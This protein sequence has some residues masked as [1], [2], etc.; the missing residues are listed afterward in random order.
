M[1]IVVAARRSTGNRAGAAG[2]RW[3]SI[4]IHMHMPAVPPVTRGY[5][6]PVPSPRPDSDSVAA[7]GSPGADRPEGSR[8][9]T[10]VRDGSVARDTSAQDA[11]VPWTLPRQRQSPTDQPAPA[12]RGRGQRERGRGPHAPD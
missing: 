12:E 9:V 10:G 2:P 8:V 4:C 3:E 7:G 11:D 1:V 5:L 6:P